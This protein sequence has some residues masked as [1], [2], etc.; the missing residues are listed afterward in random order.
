ML[1]GIAQQTFIYYLDTLVHFDTYFIID[2]HLYNKIL[3]PAV[4]SVVFCVFSVTRFFRRIFSQ[5]TNLED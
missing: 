4:Y 5:I 1:H 3:F 2:N